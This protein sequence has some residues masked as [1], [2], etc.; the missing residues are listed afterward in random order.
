MTDLSR[1]IQDA[2]GTGVD[3]VTPL[4]GGCV[5]EVHRVDLGDGTRVVAK[6]DRGASAALSIEG[7]MLDYLAEHSSLPVPRVLHATDELLLMEFVET[8]RAGAG[9][10]D[11]AAALLAD[12]HAIG[13]GRAYGLERDTLIGG[14]PQPNAW[15][16][17]WIEFYAE[18]RLIEMARQAER[19]GRIDRRLRGRVERLDSRLDRLIEEPPAPSLIH[20]D[21]WSGNVLTSAGRVAAFID[22]A[23]YY[24]DAEVELAFIDWLHC[25]GR[26]FFDRYD[27]IRGIRPG[28]REQR[29]LVYQLYPMLVHARLFGGGY[30]GEVERSLGRLGA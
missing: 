21:V 10:E 7:W 17:S 19:A 16:T 20:G 25:F 8:G 23:I 18:R 22:P 24:A 2:L 4:S 29:C 12:L 11:H 28:F 5:G 15:C 1:A 14:L 3:R 27:A 26:W 6:V 30:V 9:V 13:A